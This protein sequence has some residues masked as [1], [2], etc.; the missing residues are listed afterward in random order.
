MPGDRFSS[1]RLPPSRVLS[2]DEFRELIQR[3][4]SGDKE[5][6]DELIQANLRLIMSIVSRFPECGEDKDELFQVG[7]IGLLKAVDRFDPS[8]NVKFS[9]YAVPVI[10]GEIR[11][12][13]RDYQP[14]HVSRSVR[15]LAAAAR[16]K[17]SELISS[18]GREPGIGE[19]AAA[20]KVSPEEIVEAFEATSPPVYLFD[21]TE[22]EEGERPIR[23]MDQISDS[24]DSF[25]QFES[26]AVREALERLP[27]RE[28]RILLLRYFNDLS[29]QE[30]SNIMG[31]SQAQI[32]RL[33]KKALKAIHAELA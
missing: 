2:D 5:S 31:I 32:C 15:A 8:F 14:V 30:V 1:L 24:D 9:T 12:H 16:E 26:I 29:Q 10:I 19:L 23:L 20:L 6:R 25:Q 21:E 18:L 13:L 17:R 11:K 4:H 7:C 22:D 33:E 28:R 27:E 3:A